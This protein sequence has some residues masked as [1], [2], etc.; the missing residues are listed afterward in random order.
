MS[1]ANRD[2]LKSMLNN[3]I[4]DR[5]EEANADFS[6]YF[7]TKAKSITEDFLNIPTTCA[8]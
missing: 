7:A 5:V 3:L 6:A 1:D 2:A 8:A 4:N